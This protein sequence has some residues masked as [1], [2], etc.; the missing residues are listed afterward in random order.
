MND[1]RW[2]I[3]REFYSK[4]FNIPEDLVDLVASNDIIL[5]C[6]SG[7]SNSSIS[8]ILD[9]DEDSIKDIL[10]T[11]LDFNG[12]EYDLQLNPY[13]VFNDLANKGKTLFQPFQEELISSFG[14]LLVDEDI[15]TMF[16]ICRIY[17]KLELLL[18]REWV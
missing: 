7:S 17:S 8:R 1:T 3:I 18:D 5:M 6:V 13:R 10:S 15:K 4:N 14:P 9:I 11:V 2:N 12:W 16:R